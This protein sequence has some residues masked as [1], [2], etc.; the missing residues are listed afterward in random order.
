[1][2]GISDHGT[3]G[4]GELTSTHGVHL[5]MSLPAAAPDA[6]QAV[7]AMADRNGGPHSPMGGHDMGLAGLCLAVLVAVLI[8]GATLWRMRDHTLRAGSA[9]R[10]SRIAGTA[11]ARAPT[12]P[13]Q[14][15]LSIQRC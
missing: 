10:P 12:P 14:L 7:V 15:A 11:R 3:A 9:P 5:S 6:A 4:P 1:M 2:H 8:L 13:D